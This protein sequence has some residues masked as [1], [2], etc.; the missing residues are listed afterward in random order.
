MIR[1][2]FIVSFLALDDISPVYLDICRFEL[3]VGFHNQLMFRK[4]ETSW[5]RNSE[6]FVIYKT[7]EELCLTKVSELRN[8]LYI[9][10][11]PT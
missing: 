3:C 2:N 8:V 5:F 9:W 11:F 6:T 1:R 10:L 7:L 4:Y